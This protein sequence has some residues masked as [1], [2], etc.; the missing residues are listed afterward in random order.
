MYQKTKKFSKKLAAAAVASV[1]VVSVGTSSIFA[2]AAELSADGRFYSDYTSQEIAEQEAEKLNK[3]LAAEGIVMLKND[4][5]LPVAA[6]SKVSVLGIAQDCL[7]ETSGSITES[8]SSAGF[9]VN[10]TLEE[11]YTSDSSTYSNFGTETSLNN[12]QKQ[13][14][15]IYSD[16]GVVVI[17]RGTAGE[18][19]DRSTAIDETDDETYLGKDTGWEHEAHSNDGNGNDYKHELQLTESEEE[20]IKLA[21]QYC[22]KVVVLYS[23][24]Y[25]FE[26][27]NLQNDS[28]I[29]GIY[30]IGRLGDGGID[31]VGEILTGEINPSGK[32]VDEWTRDFTNDPTYANAFASSYGSSGYS[33]I[34]Y[35]E[36]IYLGYKYYETYWYEATQGNAK[37][38]ISGTDA[39]ADAWYDYNVVYP[40]GYGLSYT[41]FSYELKSITDN[42]GNSFGGTISAESLASETSAAK[43]STLYAEVE[44]TNIGDYAGKDTVQ[45]YITAPYTSGGIEKSYLTLVGYAKTDEI[46]AGSTDTVTVAFN[47]QDFA[48][49]DDTDA[50]GDGHTGYELEAGEYTIH[51]MNSSSHENVGTDAYAFQTFTISGTAYLDLDDYSG[52]TISNLFSEEN[53][54]YYSMAVSTDTGS[55]TEATTLSRSDFDAT[56]PTAPTSSQLTLSSSALAKINEYEYIDAEYIDDSQYPWYV[57]SVP[58]GWTQGAGTVGEDGLYGITLDDMAG[59]SLDDDKWVTFMNQ[60]TWDEIASI[61]NNGYHLTGAVSTIG[62]LESND[63]NG[64]NY[65]WNSITWVGEPTIAA[66]WNTELCEEYGMMVGNLALFQDM[67]GWYG[68]GVNTHRSP[69]SGRNPEYYSQ[70]SIQGG[71]IAAAVCR[72]AQ[73]T[74]I[75]VYLKH[76]AMYDI[77]S[78]YGT[79]FCNASEQN[80]RENYLKIFQMCMQEGGASAAMSAFNRVGYV[81]VGQNYNLIQGLA[82]DEWG[83]DGFVVTDIYSNIPTMTIDGL[84]RAGAEIPDGDLS[85]STYSYTNSEGTTISGSKALSGEWDATNNCVLVNGEASA[86]QWYCARMSAMRVLYNAANS[87]A[88]HNGIT[89]T[90]FDEEVEATQGQSL[91][92]SI[93]PEQYTAEDSGY[94]I[95]Y[96]ITS[97]ELPTGLSINNGVL[98]G[99]P[100]SGGTYNIALEMTVDGWI[101]IDVNLTITVASIIEMED[102][103]TAL[104]TGD[105]V[106][107]YVSID[108][109]D[110]SYNSYTVSISEG[111]L[112]D[113]LSMASDGRITGTV[114]TAGTYSFT[115]AVKAE[116]TNTYVL[117]MSS[118]YKEVFMAASGSSTEEELIA[119]ILSSAYANMGFVAYDNETF[120]YTY[121]ITV[122][123]EEVASS[124]TVED[125]ALN[126]DGNIVITYTDGTTSTIEIS[127]SE[128]G[129]TITDYVK[130]VTTDSNGNIVVTLADGTSTTIE[131]AEGKYVS[132]VASNGDGTITVTYSDNTTSTVTISESSDGSGCSGSIVPTIATVAAMFGIF[133]AAVV[134]VRKKKSSKED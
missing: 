108:L 90:S 14:L 99:I 73:S 87:A 65:T 52:N 63:E 62:K 81:Y 71:Y 56:A 103:I 48:S 86:T 107:E 118:V 106:D 54:D 16:L 64:P 24:S 116:D 88:N 78:L 66:T 5:S 110:V 95:S 102:D 15:R 93:L 84:I 36:D 13:S 101:K 9:K 134:V 28:K 80:M 4:G 91:S 34:D 26:M 33:G 126:S 109:S 125:V 58:S 47:V 55:M 124:A 38:T 69:F 41:E 120:Y 112:P 35:E 1:L 85:R 3:E 76:Y 53:G 21:E 100:T 67:T 29:N 123:G 49:Y 68:P 115:V 23:A 119:W 117:N 20:L 72:G 129:E 22:D 46:K 113:G 74:G 27:A 40:M 111:A 31:A 130:S 89:E 75:N 92:V 10:P 131:I 7:I 57:E 82:R 127:S 83:W 132:G 105:T 128:T 19:S 94:D 96:V 121:T 11:L 42:N 70:D 44:V 50:N 39:T 114:T 2:S 8:L 59:I 77:C 98:S 79:G 97:G 133:A 25:T 17:G 12:T 37:P 6:G 60:L 51:I 104:S 61:L 30:W 122:T 43:I 32:V 45:V 18:S